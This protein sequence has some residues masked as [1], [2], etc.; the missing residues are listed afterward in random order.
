MIR[1]GTPAT[2]T[3]S[4]TSWV[5]IAPAATTEPLPIWTPSITTALAPI[6]TLSPTRTGSALA[7]SI[8][9]AKTAPAP[10]WLF[11]PTIA[12]PPRM[13]PMSIMVP[14]PISAPILITAPIMITA[15]SPIST[16][17]RIIAPGSIRALIARLSSKG[18][19][20]LRASC[21]TT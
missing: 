16:W 14:A 17:S 8:T 3:F 20:E 4:G 7:G 10:T 21:S 18:T 15:L 6:R 19:A 9:P 2:T 13:A 12:R 11:F 1:A 5:T